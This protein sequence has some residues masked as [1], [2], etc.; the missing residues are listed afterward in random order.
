MEFSSQLA[1]VYAFIK[2]NGIKVNSA[3]SAWGADRWEM[4]YK[5]KE[6]FA[7]LEDDGYT[8][9]VGSST[10]WAAETGGKGIQMRRGERGDLT[11]L[12]LTV[13]NR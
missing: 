6:I 3:G 1:Q 7:T 10:V 4:T 5:G 11:A 12:W 2:D 9:T 13:V 8:R